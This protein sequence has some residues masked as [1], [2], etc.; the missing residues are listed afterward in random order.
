MRFK[1]I[2]HEFLKELQEADIEFC[3]ACPNIGTFFL[4]IQNVFDILEDRA[5]FFARRYQ[6]SEEEWSD[7]ERQRDD[8]RGMGLSIDAYIERILGRQS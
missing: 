5:K 4:D 1:K 2:K 7:F 6:I 3:F 8:P